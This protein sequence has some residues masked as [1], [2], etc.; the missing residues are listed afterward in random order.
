MGSGAV[1]NGDLDVGE[2]VVIVG[3]DVDMVIVVG[4]RMVVPIVGIDEL[5]VFRRSCVLRR[6][7]MF[8]VGLRGNNSRRAVFGS[9]H[10]NFGDHAYSLTPI[11][12]ER[13]IELG[14]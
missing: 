2:V 3:C 7:W 11:V 14:Q 8:M 10:C 12:I 4:D 9:G 6:D 1:D 13:Y 5:G